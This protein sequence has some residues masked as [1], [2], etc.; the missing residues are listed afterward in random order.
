M[1]LDLEESGIRGIQ[2]NLERIAF[3]Q[4]MYALS[5]YSTDQDVSVQHER[6]TISHDAS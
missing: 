3:N 1:L 6:S 4:L 2:I 5:Q